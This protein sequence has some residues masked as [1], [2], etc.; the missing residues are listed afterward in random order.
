M[1]SEQIRST[2]LDFFGERDHLAM[3]EGPLTPADDSLLFTNAG[4][5]QFK[6]YFV[7]EQQPP[8]P[9][10]MTVQR[11]VRTV[12]IDNIGHT[13]RHATSFEMLGNFS[14]HDYGKIESMAWALE[15]LTGGFGFD[16]ERLWVT[17][18]RGDEETV[19]LWGKLGFAAQRIQ[20]LGPQ[21]NLWSMDV[22]GGPS[23]PTT[24]I[25]YDRGEAFGRDGGPEVNS[26]RYLEVWNLVFMGYRY[27][28]TGMGL[29]RMAMLLQEVPH[30]QAIDLVRPLFDAVLALTWR[31]DELRAHRII[32][33][34]LRTSLLM[35]GEGVM[36]STA[37]PG[38]VLRRLLRRAV[39]QLHRLGVR[40]PRLGS[41]TGN[42]VIER[43]E[44]VFERTLRSGS[45][46]LQRE[47]SRGT[48]DAQTVFKLHD[49]H[50]FPIDLTE[51]IAIDAGVPIDRRG[52]E[53]LMA[54]Q[55]ARSRGT[56][57]RPGGDAVQE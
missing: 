52:F 4:M 38:Y 14:F 51:E 57:R 28:D 26:E 49:T 37:G 2:F 27:V 50:G 35:I 11:C 25:F 12:D 46:L 21:D 53:T 20:R 18:L 31:D 30:L 10:L 54:E 56:F 43:E 55:R 42:P 40:E 36:P 39:Y 5:V 22:P 13:T 33:D 29:D 32:T 41:L 1:K 6:P 19:A 3:P 15:L 23:G 7:G 47:L 48:L 44:R 24:E 16:R 8:R 45:R 9:R 17:V 34:H